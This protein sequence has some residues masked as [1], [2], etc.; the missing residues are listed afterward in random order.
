MPNTWQGGFTAGVTITN[1]GSTAADGWTLRFSRPGDQR[2]T[3]WWNADIEQDGAVVTP[4]NV[5]HNAAIAPGGNQAFGFRATYSGNN[6]AA[7]DFLVDDWIDTG[8]QALGAQRLV[9][10]TGATWLGV[11]VVVDALES[12]VVRRRLGVRSLIHHRDL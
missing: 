2:I 4:R 10:D 1:T 6:T 9:E 12:N 7:S 3:N 5:G 8:G 11:A